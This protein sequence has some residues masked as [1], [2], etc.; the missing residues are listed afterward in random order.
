MP[1]YVAGHVKAKI[2]GQDDFLQTLITCSLLFGR[3][4]C[5]VRRSFYLFASG[6]DHSYGRVV[7]KGISVWSLVISIGSNVFV[8][9][10]SMLSIPILFHVQTVGSV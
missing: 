3:P 2:L 5:G 8:N 1:C 4:L 7:P 9:L 10:L 6:T